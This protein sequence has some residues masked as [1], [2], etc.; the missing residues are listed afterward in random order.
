MATGLIL[1]CSGAGAPRHDQRSLISFV[2]E[3]SEVGLG[4]CFARFFEKLR[5][6]L[7]KIFFTNYMKSSIYWA[8]S[9][10]FR[11]AGKIL[12]KIIHPA[13]ISWVLPRFRNKT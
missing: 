3:V 4:L 6:T 7:G 2:K 13:Q 1:D 12:C 10:P 11:I 8:K 5:G 9:I